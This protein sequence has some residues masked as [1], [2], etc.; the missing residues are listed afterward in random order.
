MQEIA[1]N[2]YL[3]SRFPPYNLGAI[4]TE[5]GVIVVDAPPCPSH[6]SAWME[7]LRD[8]WDEP[9][10][11]VLTDAQ[12]E[13]LVG[14]AL[15]QVP[16][17]AAKATADCLATFDEK[18]W[19]EMLHS[20]GQAFPDEVEALASLQTHRP[21]L[22]IHNTLRLHY[23]SP[24]LT[25]Q[26]LHGSAVSSLMLYDPEHKVL[27][28]GDTVVVGQPPDLQYTPDFGAWL[29]TLA[30]LARQKDLKWIVPGRGPGPIPRGDL[31][32]QQEFMRDLEHVAGR[33]AR[34]SDISEGLAQATTDLQQAFY[35]HA[36]RGSA[37][38]KTLRQ[39]LELLA[40]QK[41]AQRL[42]AAAQK[43]TDQKASAESAVAGKPER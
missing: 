22:A 41:R 3:E 2:T 4:V 12:P 16:I 40:N 42:E 38:H 39:D 43:A 33:L 37:I 35:P 31:E 10:F 6:A 19:P 23:T 17:I 26:L 24:P 25:F 9:R 13:R 7:E 11:L 1:P 34:K 14:A 20:V 21:T 18:T 8:M 28:A 27:F 32:V 30:T 15:C 29:K 36:S 5:A